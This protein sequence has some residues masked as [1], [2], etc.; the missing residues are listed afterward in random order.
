VID[1]EAAGV[2]TEKGNKLDV[3]LG[4]GFTEEALE[5]FR[6]RSGW[7]QE[8]RLLSLPVATPGVRLTLRTVRG[9]A[10]AQDSDEDPGNEWQVVTRVAPTEAQVRA[11]RFQWAI[12]PHVRSNAIVVGNENR[13]LGVGAGQMNRVQSV[14]LALEQAGDLAKGAVLASDAF[15]PFPDSIEAAGKAGIVAIVQ[16]GGSKKDSAVVNAA[17]EWGIA[18]VLTG[19]R[20]FLH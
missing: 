19:T 7:G 2:M 17:D 12:I 4:A 1:E 20:H 11:L 8:V 5:V 10:L 18:M 6:K 16:P 15:F 9:G 13:L 3:I 14:C